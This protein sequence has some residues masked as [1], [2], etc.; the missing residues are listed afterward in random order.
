MSDFISLF[1]GVDNDD[2]CLCAKFHL[3][4]QCIH[5]HF[6]QDKE[7]CHYFGASL[8]QNRAQVISKL[9]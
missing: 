7:Y 3:G 4:E 9:H 2:Q 6:L 1:C 8:G 5:A